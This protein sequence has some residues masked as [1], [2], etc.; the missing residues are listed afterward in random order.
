M[1]TAMGCT[2][3]GLLFFP[4][5]FHQAPGRVHRD[6]MV[7]EMQGF[8]LSTPQSFSISAKLSCF[9]P[10]LA[11]LLALNSQDPCGEKRID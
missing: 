5:P 2:K 4:T 11:C 3:S 9:Q 6:R 10:S 1:Q 7:L 8:F